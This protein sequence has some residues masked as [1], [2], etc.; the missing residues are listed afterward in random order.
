MRNPKNIDLKAD[1]N[2][3]PVKEAIRKKS[4]AFSFSKM[5]VSHKPK[6]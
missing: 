1:Q 6:V 5:S 4:G 3:L 2:L